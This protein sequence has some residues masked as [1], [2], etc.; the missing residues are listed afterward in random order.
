MKIVSIINSADAAGAENLILNWMNWEGNSQNHS[1]IIL[2]RP[3][4]LSEKYS[5]IFN[6]V[7]YLGMSYNPIRMVIA[8]FRAYI[9]IRQANPDVIHTHLLQSDLLGIILPLKGIKLISTVHSASLLA[10]KKWQSRFL[11]KVIAKLSFK[12]DHIISTSPASTIYC[13]N[14]GYKVEKVE[15]IRNVSR[16]TLHSCDE[17]KKFEGA[18]LSLSRWHPVK[19]HET[20]LGGFAL[21]ALRHEKCELVLSGEGI[22]VHN[23]G[24]EE[25]L[26]RYNLREKVI[27]STNKDNVQRC[28]ED[29]K[30]LV[31]SS[32]S[33]SFP[34]AALESFSVSTPVVISQFQGYSEF[35]IS[36]ELSFGVGESKELAQSM[37]Y[38]CSLKIRDYSLIID[39]VRS[40]NLTFGS[41][42]KWI[43]AHLR[44]Y[45]LP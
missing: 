31:I 39:N 27:I 30:A 18:Y 23:L 35:S 11:Q 4:T 1:L 2:T 33:E 44:M 32:V 17:V 41:V 26:S 36:P 37:D 21:H 25:M 16:F 38:L 8:V 3:G 10:E 6:D 9:K 43:D 29:A 7:T 24:L 19:D 5:T 42:H 14:L 28:L 12:F 15:E 20:L 40:H 34:M 22:D 45:S 13:R